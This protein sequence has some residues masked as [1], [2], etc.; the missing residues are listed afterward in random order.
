ME[1]DSIANV[2]SYAGLASVFMNWESM[3]TI[4]LIVS[5]IILNVLRIR[6]N[7]VKRNR[8]QEEG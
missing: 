1:K 3:L 6:D 2:V 5:G 4:V 8:E 7:I